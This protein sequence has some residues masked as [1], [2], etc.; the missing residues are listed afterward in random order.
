MVVREGQLRASSSR[1]L[2][3][4]KPL[5]YCNLYPFHCKNSGREGCP[6]RMKFL[7]EKVRHRIMS[8]PCLTAS[9]GQQPLLSERTVA[10]KE[11]K[12]GESPVGAAERRGEQVGR[13][14]EQAFSPLPLR[15]P[16]GALHAACCNKKQ[17]DKRQREVGMVT[18]CNN[19]KGID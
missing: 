5:V 11:G 6:P 15:S 17:T 14:D 19:Q 13:R 4:H 10:K 3:F 12:R 18:N 16:Q 7:R 2:Y 1:L 8:R 9:K